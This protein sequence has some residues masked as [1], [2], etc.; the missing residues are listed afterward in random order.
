MATY[1][2]MPDDDATGQGRALALAD[3]AVRMGFLR[4]V[5]GILT[6]QL[7]L[8]TAIAAPICMLGKEWVVGHVWLMYAAIAMT[9]VCMC[10]M[11]CNRDM[12]RK[13][14]QNYAFLSVFTACTGVLVGFASAAA[15]WQTVMLSAGVTALVFLSMTAYA[16]TTKSDFTGFGPYLFAAILSLCMFSLVIMICGMFGAPVRGMM[17]V[18]DFL[19]ILL[20][21]LFIVYDTQVMMGGKHKFSLDVDEYVFAALNLYLDIIDLFLLLLDLLGSRR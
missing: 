13:F 10:A 18:Y 16:W 3:A 7:L 14:P 17:V 5:Y 4:K 11:M 12:T 6:A 19:G 2:P 21:S 8:T 15:S 1:Q 20:F 9:W